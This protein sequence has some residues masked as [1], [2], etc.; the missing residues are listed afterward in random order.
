MHFVPASR[1]VND[2]TGE[3]VMYA[4]DVSTIAGNWRLE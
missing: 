4:Q 3:I 1:M 2:V